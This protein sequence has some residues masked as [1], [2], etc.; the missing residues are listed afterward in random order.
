MNHTD[1]DA[2]PSFCR[3]YLSYIRNVKNLSPKTVSQYYL[4]LKLF[5]QWVADTN[6]VIS[7]DPTIASDGRWVDINIVKKITF[8]DLLSYLDYTSTQRD[9]KS[10]ARSR[11]ISSLR[12]F[13]KYLQRSNKIDENPALNLEVPKTPKQ[14]PVHLNLFEAKELLESIDGKN[15]KRNF[16]IITLFLNCGMRLSELVGLN[17]QDVDFDRQAVVVRGKGNKER[18]LHLNNMCIDAINDYLEERMTLINL[19]PDAKKALFV[20][21]N[22]NRISNRMVQTMIKSFIEKSGLDAEKYSTHKLRH[23]AATLMYQNGVDV[24]VLQEV[25]G[26]ANL[27]TTQIYT[28]IGDTQV[29][30][31]IESNP[32]DSVKIK[33]HKQ[34][35][36]DD[37]K[38]E[39]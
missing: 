17:I 2:V 32:L 18:N 7:P 13:F 10:R 30:D 1:F 33:K 37:Y 35:K 3:E 15:Y 5:F 11:K 26:H 23:T 36:I 8:G 25:L 19:K 16:C 20:S 24:R 4:D 9:N 21:R 27:G 29:E 22:G 12:G 6:S 38:K 39:S 14:L 31:A 34:T 28:H